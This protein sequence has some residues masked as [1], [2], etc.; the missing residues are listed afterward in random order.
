MLPLLLLCQDVR[1]GYHYDFFCDST[2]NPKGQVP[3]LLGTERHCRFPRELVVEVGK[4]DSGQV[5][6]QAY[7]DL[8]VHFIS[9]WVAGGWLFQLSCCMLHC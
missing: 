7:T 9:P 3:A 5:E 4:I 1:L 2:W 8:L 6:K